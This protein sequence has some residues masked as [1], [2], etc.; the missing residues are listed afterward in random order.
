[1][2]KADKFK[3]FCKGVKGSSPFRKLPEFDL[4]WSWCIDYM[5]TVCLGCMKHLLFIWISSKEFQKYWRI[6]IRS[7]G[8]LITILDQLFVKFKIPKQISRKPGD[9]G[10]ADQWKANELRNFLL[11]FGPIVLNGLLKEQYLKNFCLLSEA[12]FIFCQNEISKEEFHEAS[13]KL[14]KFVSEYEELYGTVNMFYN[15][16]LLTHIPSAVLN[17]GPLIHYSTFAYESMNNFVS[18]FIQGTNRIIQE[19]TM[20]LLIYQSRFLGET[21]N[22]P[23]KFKMRISDVN[24]STKPSKVKLSPTQNS[25]IE[26]KLNTAEILEV[27]SATYRGMFIER[28]DEKV[29]SSCDCFVELH[30]GT[31]GIVEK[32]LIHNGLPIILI[33]SEY[34]K[35]LVTGHIV[36]LE[37]RNE[38]VYKIAIFDDLKRKCIFYNDGIYTFFPNLLEFD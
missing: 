12:I 24:L 10:S 2:D 16:H 33:G 8:Q 4:V 26:S 1:M 29:K 19:A 5:H 35:S 23:K 14:Y 31:F 22:Q 30:D 9:I 18:S 11:F 3:K 6:I 20:K 25:Y 17:C 13:N 34:K 27:R 32:I 37:K 21:L 36:H 7:R 38:T 28:I 15:F